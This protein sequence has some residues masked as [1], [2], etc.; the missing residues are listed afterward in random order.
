MRYR[1][2]SPTLQL[3]LAADV[4]RVVLD[5]RTALGWSQEELSR[6]SGL[7]QSAISR[8]E[9]GLHSGLDLDD[10]D[11][12]AAA[13]GGRLRLVFEAP[14]LADRTRQRDRVHARCIGFVARRL[15]R[16]GWLVL[17]EVEIAGSAGP[18]WIDVLAYQPDSATLLVV[19]VKT[20]VHDVGRIQRTLDWYERRSWS[21]AR[22]SGWRPARSV[23]ALLVLET[24]AVDTAVRDNR[25]LLGRTFGGRVED[26]S[27]LVDGSA[28]GSPMSRRYIAGFDPRS[29]RAT[30]L[31][32]TKLQGRRTPP[33]YL[34]YADAAR[35][36]SR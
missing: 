29:R 2:V 20:E 32:P 19:E 35:R 33:A 7:S 3:H 17:T 24:A 36:L 23:G 22:R 30:W 31:R 1:G 27:A 34:D 26:L 25:D 4:G 15:E 13:C 12:L 28:P 10:L 8:L 21:A 11:R 18:G 14:F 5:A 16:A 9:R 6:R